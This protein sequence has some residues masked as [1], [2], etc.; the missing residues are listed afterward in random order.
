MDKN[1][2]AVPTDDHR[3]LDRTELQVAEQRSEAG[4]CFPIRELEQVGCV[5]MQ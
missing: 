2:Q 4:C 1:L 3:G 5:A